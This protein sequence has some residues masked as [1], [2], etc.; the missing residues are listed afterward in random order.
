LRREPVRVCTSK[1]WRTSVALCTSA[2]TTVAGPMGQ[3]CLAWS[4]MGG[5]AAST[6][7]ATAG[8][9]LGRPA[10]QD[11]R[12][13]ASSHPGLRA[14]ACHCTRATRGPRAESSTTSCSLT[15]PVVERRAYKQRAAR[16]RQTPKAFG[17]AEWKAV[18]EDAVHPT[19]AATHTHVCSWSDSCAMSSR[20]GRNAS[21][22]IITG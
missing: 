4:C 20:C 14:H 17:R 2:A 19:E 12:G 10:R 3:Q 8:V 13:R 21:H 1:T 11:A 16:V 7:L 15:V 5:L 6:A 9:S 22:V 18:K